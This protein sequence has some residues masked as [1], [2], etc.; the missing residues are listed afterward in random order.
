MAGTDLPSSLQSWH[1]IINCLQS[2]NKLWVTFAALQPS[3]AHIKGSRSKLRLQVQRS[4]T[5]GGIKG[6]CKIYHLSWV[7]AWQA[8]LTWPL[9]YSVFTHAQRALT[10]NSPSLT[11]ALMSS[12]RI[13]NAEASWVANFAIA[14]TILAWCKASHRRPPWF[15]T[16]KSVS[17]SI[18]LYF[19]VINRLSW[20]TG[21]IFNKLT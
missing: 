20:E 16:S 12:I 15:A 5:A 2:F 7:L 4:W 17:A 21:D 1:F 9:I 14:I 19:M 10:T 11:S 3:Q 13:N 6:H 18:H 8:C